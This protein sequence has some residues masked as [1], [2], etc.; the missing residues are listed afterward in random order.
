MSACKLLEALPAALQQHQL[1]VLDLS[2]CERLTEVPWSVLRACAQLQ[3][4]TTAKCGRLRSLPSSLGCL[5][6]L[7]SLDC[8][9]C[10]Q[11]QACSVQLPAVWLHIRKS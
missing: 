4:L 11:L 6:A 7:Q 1:T 5:G 8:S 10:S 9:G 3:R 2:E